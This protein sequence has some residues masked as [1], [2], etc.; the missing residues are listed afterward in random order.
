MQ[1][2]K[3]I[4][5]SKTEECKWYKKHPNHSNQEAPGEKYFPCF[6]PSIINLNNSADLYLKVFPT[7][8]SSWSFF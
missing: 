5:I 8:F 2:S 7:E 3:F 6:C 4:H 1:Q